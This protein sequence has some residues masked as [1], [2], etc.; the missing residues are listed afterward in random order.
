MGIS[1]GKRKE[2]EDERRGKDGSIVRSFE[3]GT[4][5]AAVAVAGDER[6]HQSRWDRSCF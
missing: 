2:E 4:V 5:A 1:R 3:T 6:A